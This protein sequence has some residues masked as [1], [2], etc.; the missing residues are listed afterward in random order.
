MVEV[1]IVHGSGEVAEVKRGAKRKI[2]AVVLADS[3]VVYAD[4][5]A[6]D[7][8]KADRSAV[9]AHLANT[10]AGA[11]ITSRPYGVAA[12]MNEEPRDIFVNAVQVV[13]FLDLA[14]IGGKEAEVAAALNALGAL[15]TG[16]VYVSQADDVAPLD[17]LSGEGVVN[18]TFS[19]KHLRGWLEHKSHKLL[20]LIRED[21]LD[22]KCC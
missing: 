5:G 4:H 8:T 14:T 16:K 12:S 6:L 2:L 9:A 20:L 3:E 13:L 7:V 11:F 10:G 19:G 18:A 17:C 21:S 15:T 1:K 22:S